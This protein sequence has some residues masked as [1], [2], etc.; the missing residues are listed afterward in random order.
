MVVAAATLLG[1]DVAHE[2]KR[3]PTPG[4]DAKCLLYMT[5]K[6][7]I[8]ICLQIFDFTYFCYQ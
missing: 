1:L 4:L 3:L 7:E 5:E 8:A 6:M 2:T